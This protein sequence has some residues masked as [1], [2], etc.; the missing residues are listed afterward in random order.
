LRSTFRLAVRDL[1]AVHESALVGVAALLCAIVA[2][3]LFMLARYQRALRHD[4]EE[5]LARGDREPWAPAGGW[6]V[7]LLPFVTWIGA[8]WAPCTGS[9]RRSAH[10]SR[11][12]RA[13]ALLLIV[14]ALLVPAYQFAVGLYGLAADPTVR[15]DRGGQR[16][17][18]LI[19]S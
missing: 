13:A 4:V 18:R 6:F 19:A 11:R 5:W 9:S 1:T 3:S 14:A 12:A 15:H 7:V 8:G 10:A 16:R 17:L 2:F